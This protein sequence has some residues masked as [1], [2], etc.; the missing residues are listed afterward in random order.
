MEEEKKFYFNLQLFADGGDGSGGSDG[1][2]GKDSGGKD[3]PDKSGG[4]DPKDKGPDKDK[5]EKLDEAA[6]Q[7]RIDEALK[8]AKEKWDKEA[9]DKRK[10]DER[11]SKLSEQE[12]KSEELKKK[13][14]EL[15]AKEKELKKKDMQLEMAKVL[16]DRHIPQEFSEYLMAKDSAETLKRVTTFEKAYKKAVDAGVNE[17]LKGKPPKAGGSG[18]GE[19]AHTKNG[20]FEAIF[21]NQSK[22]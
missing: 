4:G 12:R 8:A 3:G 11:L 7:K 15:E 20:F 13:Q 9:E 21:K 16:S 18:G 14:K 2:G 1:G 19:K 5:G 22:R 6:V 10:E 17:R